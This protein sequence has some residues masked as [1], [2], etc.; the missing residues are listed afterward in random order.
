MMT[1]Q[2]REAEPSRPNFLA[3][4][5]IGAGV[6][7]LLG[8]LNVLGASA[9]SVLA[10]F[11]PLII[12]AIGVNLLLGRNNPAMSRMIAIVTI[13]IFVALMLLGP[14]L[15]LAQNVE[16]Q[17]QT[18]SEAV[19]DAQSAVVNLN[20]SLGD[21]T[22]T[23]GSSSDLISARL[24]YI[25][26][27]EFDVENEG[28][29]R[30]VT[31]SNEVGPNSGSFSFFPFFNFG[32][33]SPDLGWDVVLTP[34]IPLTLNVSG[35]VGN[36]ELDLDGLQIE[37]LSVNSGVGNTMVMLPALENEYRVD[38]NGGVGETDV[39]VAEGASIVLDINGGVGNITV[40][41]PDDAAVRLD[42]DGG[43]GNINIVGSYTRISG[44]GDNG[45]WESESY[46][47]ATNRIEITVDG[48]VGNFT[49]R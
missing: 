5:L 34:N 44:E 30:V 37:R 13:I 23:A 35:G 10:R 42:A 24:R 38:I 39:T 36:N 8:Q 20:L 32:T 49:L 18:F 6:V 16:V 21:S 15:G 7:W 22:V 9:F 4:L 31:L 14:S 12:V 17:T 25:G 29:E 33:D 1:T 27:V 43:V 11:W 19:D 2:Y 48:G 46:D 26:D 3:I 28:N 41:V 45:V 40:D 47:D